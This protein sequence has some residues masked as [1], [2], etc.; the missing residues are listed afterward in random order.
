MIEVEPCGRKEKNDVD[1]PDRQ[2]PVA[3]NR[4]RGGEGQGWPC[5]LGSVQER[6]VSLST[7]LPSFNPIDAVLCW[8]Q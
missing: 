6:C 2:W 5:P 1:T 7:G 8:T 4:I 3:V